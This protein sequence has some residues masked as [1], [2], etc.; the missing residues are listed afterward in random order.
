MPGCA[1]A[2]TLKHSAKARP[3]VTTRLANVVDAVKP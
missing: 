2:M 1:G 3:L